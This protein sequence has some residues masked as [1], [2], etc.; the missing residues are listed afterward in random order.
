MNRKNK[1]MQFVSVSAVIVS[2]S[3]LMP[4]LQGCEKK[5]P[6]KIAKPQSEA[7]PL[8][9]PQEAQT[10]AANQEAVGE[11][12]YVYQPRDRRDPFMPLIVP[13]K[14]TETKLTDAGR[15][16]TLE[17]YDISEFALL[18]IAKKGVKYYALL[19]TPDNRSFTVNKG[20]RIG[21]NKGRVEEITSNRVVLMEHVKDF[22][23]EIR[24]KQV[25]LELLKER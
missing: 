19:V 20:A 14:K 4:V 6:V 3:L 16:G 1:I 7:S 15:L 17:S 25:T 18:A 10:E 11:E 23:G 21:L 12:G 2:L 9:K 5:Q 8:A 24:P 22:R 13:K